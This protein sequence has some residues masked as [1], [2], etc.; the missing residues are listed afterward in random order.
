MYYDYILDQ[1]FPSKK[2]FFFL[3]F[4]DQLNSHKRLKLTWFD[5]CIFDLTFYNFLQFFYTSSLTQ[6][7][8]NE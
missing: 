7:I 4:L 3:I 2:F 6:D 8:E 5:I 1:R